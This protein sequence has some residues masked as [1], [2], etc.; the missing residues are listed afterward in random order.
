MSAPRM[1]TRQ[2]QVATVAERWKA[3]Y[4]TR[5]GWTQVMGGS[6]RDYYDRLAALDLSTATTDDVK[7]IIGNDSW[8][9]LDCGGCGKGADAV[10]LFGADDGDES[11]LL[12]R[13]CL[14]TGA[15]LFAAEVSR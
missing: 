9:Y 8:T 6:S 1:V 12:C 2:G 15:E 5:E 3:Q 14:T 4:H 11:F 10:V 7:A 13:A